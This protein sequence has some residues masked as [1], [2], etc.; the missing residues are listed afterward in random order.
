MID[1][2]QPSG[3]G[4][5]TLSTSLMVFLLAEEEGLPWFHAVG[6]GPGLKEK[7]EN[8]VSVERQPSPVSFHDPPDIN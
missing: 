4:D 6:R 2:H 8:R 3:L 5:T 1:P 7:L